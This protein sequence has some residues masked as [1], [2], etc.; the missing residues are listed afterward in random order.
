[1]LVYLWS[2]IVAAGKAI[3]VSID[4]SYVQAVL[5]STF[6]IM[7]YTFQG[8]YRAVVWVDVL[9]GLMMILALVVLPVV[10]LI[11][12]GG[13]GGLMAQLDLASAD[14]AASGNEEGAHLGELFAGLVGLVL[15][16]SFFEDAGV[17]AGYIGQP[18]ICT[19]FMSMENP[20]HMRVA[21]LVSILF[22][23]MIC[24]G[25]VTVGLVAHG[26][27][28][29]A[30]MGPETALQVETMAGQ[31]AEVA[32]RR[33]V[34]DT[35]KVLLQLVS[36]VFPGWLAG[37]V[38]SAIMADII[39]S[40]AGYLITGASSAVED[41]YHRLFR[42]NAQQ[43]ELL[44]AGR[45]STLVLGGL[46]GAL[47][48]STD[49]L[50]KTGVVYYLVLYAWGGLAGAF[51]APV[52]MA[53]YFRRM[54]RAGCLAGIIVGSLTSVIWHNIWLAEVAYELIPAIALS[55]LATYIVSLFTQPRGAES[56]VDPTGDGVSVQ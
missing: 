21:M 20:R 49:P 29:N 35:E 54:T 33:V 12:L 7:C 39:S 15:F 23:M 45:L 2:Q 25:A 37:F 52:F 36:T 9:Q 8:G 40:A 34:H 13:W 43:R 18:H 50:S 6:V 42:R 26:W 53:I 19:R 32:G 46:A 1:M 24:A 3:Q 51:S 48:L 38:L 16:R 17:G 27:F 11:Q 41:V 4:M 30:S 14:A 10:C 47:A 31:A 44:L 22:A 5:L 28:R 56:G 55:A